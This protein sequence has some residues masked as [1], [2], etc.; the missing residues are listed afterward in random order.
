MLWQLRFVRL[1][2]IIRVASHDERLFDYLFLD[3]TFPSNG[4]R[5]DAIHDLA[6][7]RDASKD[8]VRDFLIESRFEIDT[9]LN[10]GGGDRTRV[11]E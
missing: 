1:L 6:S 11:L 10:D 8:A 2:Q 7:A 4:R 3:R 9:G 5:R